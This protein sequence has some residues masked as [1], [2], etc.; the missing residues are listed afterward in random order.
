M[1]S[2]DLGVERE[3]LRARMEAHVLTMTRGRMT[4]E[5]LEICWIAGKG[6]PAAQTVR[7]K[8][9]R[10]AWPH[11]YLNIRKDAVSGRLY[12][13][14]GEMVRFLVERELENKLPSRLPAKRKSGRPSLAELHEKGRL[15]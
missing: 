14:V 12:A 8:L 4:V 11:E 5:L 3:T 7:N 2:I 1:N 13:T 9:S 10:Q 15:P 6:F